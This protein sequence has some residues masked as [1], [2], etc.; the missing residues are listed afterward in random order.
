MLQLIPMSNLQWFTDRIGQIVTRSYGTHITDFTVTE[1]NTGYL[2]QFIEK[3]YIYTDKQ[4]NVCKYTAPSQNLRIHRKP[5]V[6][7]ESCSA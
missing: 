2:E 3:G 6:E 7:C 4:G 1:K 5:F